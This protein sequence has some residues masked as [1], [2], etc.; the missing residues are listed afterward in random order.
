MNGATPPVKTQVATYTNKNRDAI[1]A[2]TFDEITKKH[3]NAHINSAILVF[4]D[5]LF[6]NETGQK[7]VF[8]DSNMMKKHFY[9]NCSEDSCSNT[10]YGNSQR[11]DPVIK[12][13]PNSPVM[14]T[15]NSDV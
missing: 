14:H 8:I 9:C 5:E 15:E 1:N 13:Y 7:N 4:M 6:I 2:A 11:V 10:T 3:V 12:L